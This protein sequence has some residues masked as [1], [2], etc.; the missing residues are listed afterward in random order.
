V[1]D[2]C[3]S[4]GRYENGTIKPDFEKFPRGFK[5]VSSRIHN[6]G[7]KYGMYSSAG[8]YTC[9]RYTASLGK[10]KIDAQTF[11][12]WGVDYLKY[13]NCYNGGQEG[14]P[15]LSY[16]RYDAMSRALN[17]TGRPILYGMCNWGSDQP[18]AWAQT[19]AN[20]W[21]MSGDVT[22]NFSRPDSRCPCT[23]DEPGNVCQ[24]QGFHCSILNI[25][26]K[27]AR[28]SSK[29]QSGA[30]NDMD[31]LEVG[32]GGMTDD[33]Y[34]TQFSI[35]AMAASPLLMGHDVTRM[36]PQTLSILSNPAVIAIDQDPQVQSA[37]RIWRYFVADKDEYGQGEIS[38]WARVMNN[39]DVAVALVN[40]GN[41]TR[42]M[43]ATLADIWLDAGGSTAKQAR[44]GYD[45]YDLWGH[46]MDN[47]TASAVL[48][49]GAPIGTNSTMRYNAT[50]MSYAEGLRTNHTALFGTRIGSVD[51]LG[52]VRAR[53]PRHGTR[54]LRLRANGAMLDGAKDEL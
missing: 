49:G 43:N 2:D 42:E 14:T 30:Q 6:L 31:M 36:S 12:D 39:S 40:G 10:E 22:D 5:H 13:D 50:A 1:L 53:V 47:A 19:M 9:G 8:Y 48:K 25:M 4:D 21:R 15:D 46:R 35:W 23:G 37:A 29:T 45:V 27:Q 16:R 20:S 51:P 3:Y 41:K 11:A 33:E 7:L 32:N 52:T 24:L 54:L 18:W 38:M 28:I 26:N 34:L 44:M 17:A